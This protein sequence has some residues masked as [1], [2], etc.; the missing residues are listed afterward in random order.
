MRSGAA[1]Y[2]LKAF[3]VGLHPFE[4][5]IRELNLRKQF[6]DQGIIVFIIFDKKNF[7]IIFI[8][9]NFL[10]PMAIFHQRQNNELSF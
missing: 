10:P 2:L 4:R 7:Y 6:S 3:L 5:E 1:D 8:H 9:G